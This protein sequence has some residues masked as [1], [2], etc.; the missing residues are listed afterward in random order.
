[1]E[2][3]DWEISINKF[4]RMELIK[5]KKVDVNKLHIVV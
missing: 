3:I 1:M 5:H 2:K 4:S